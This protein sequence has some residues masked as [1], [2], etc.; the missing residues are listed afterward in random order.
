MTSTGFRN[1]DTARL[2]SATAWVCAMSLALFTA[3]GPVYKMTY[4]YSP[5]TSADGRVCALQ[6]DN[7]KLQ[8]DQIE[9]M[10]NLECEKSAT[11]DFD[12]CKQDPK[13][14]CIRRSCEPNRARCLDSY[15]ACYRSCGGQVT[16]EQRCVKRC[17]SDSTN[18][19]GSQSGASSASHAGANQSTCPACGHAQRPA[20]FCSKCGK[21]MDGTRTC[22]CGEALSG[23]AK[24]CPKC[25]AKAPK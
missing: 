5:P 23:D 13:A 22:K 20:R 2:H 19:G 16:T 15:H 7:I 8:C 3:C 10:K 17:P 1:V 18:A 12:A 9:D 25:G 21:A 24:F 11:A 6:C 14:F 4:A